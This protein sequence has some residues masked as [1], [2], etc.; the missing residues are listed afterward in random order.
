MKRAGGGPRPRRTALDAPAPA[1]P[2]G[3][4]WLDEITE[5]PAVADAETVGESAARRA[6]GRRA[7]ARESGRGKHRG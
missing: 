5:R 6:A 3:D 2:G 1:P 7:A 4:T